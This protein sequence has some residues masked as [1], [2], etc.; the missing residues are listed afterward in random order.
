[1]T[2]PFCGEN[3]EDF[4]KEVI[5]LSHISEDDI[6]NAKKMPVVFYCKSCK[7]FILQSVELPFNFILH[8]SCNDYW[9]FPNNKS[10][11]EGQGCCCADRYGEVKCG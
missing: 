3:S 5:R 6:K 9:F 7:K 1:L 4:I 8:Y 2:K 10:E 11:I